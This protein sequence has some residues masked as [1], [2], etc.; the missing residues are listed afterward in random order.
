MSTSLTVVDK[1]SN[2]QRNG[3]ANSVA[4]VGCSSAG[5]DNAC[6][7]FETDSLVEDTV[8]EGGAPELVARAVRVS[9]KRQVFVKAHTA[10]PGVNSA[11]TQ[12]PAATGPLITL[13][14]APWDDL[15]SMVLKITQGGAQGVGQFA[16]SRDGVN[17]DGAIDIPLPKAAVV[18]GTVDLTTITLSS[19]NTL[20]LILAFDGG[21]NL[22]TTFSGITSLANVVTQINAAITTSGTASIVGGRYLQIIDATTGTSSTILLGSGTANAALG[23]TNAQTASGSA[24][25]YLIPKT[26]TT[27]TFPAGTYVLNVLYSWSATGPKMDLTSLANALNALQASKIPFDGLVVIAQ[28]P[29]DVFEL[30][31]IGTQASTS[32]ASFAANAPRLYS[33]AMIFTPLGGTGASAITANDTAIKNGITVEDD[34]KLWIVHG[35]CYMPGTAIKG[36]IRRPLGHSAAT[37]AAAYRLSS[38]LGNGQQ[39]SLEETSL[40]GPDLVTFARDESTASIKMRAQR[41]T[42]ALTKNGAPY[43]ARGV[44]RAPSTGKFKHAGVMRMTMLA[45]RIVDDAMQQYDNDDPFLNPDGTLRDPDAA[46]IKRT[47]DRALGVLVEDEHAS[48]AA[49]TVDTTEDIGATDNLTVSFEVQHKA[50]LQTVTGKLGIVSELVLG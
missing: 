15:A 4:F 2:V 41:F 46:A 44:T 29:V 24:A 13:S 27:V 36:Q 9:K 23:F 34:P 14:G 47:I 43:I 16:I 7:Q 45:A 48:S 5:V 37:R 38:D 22:T 19:L 28:T 40:V 31:A 11:V 21:G 1:G 30:N 6:Y 25:T 3:G 49:C 18:V 35:D 42:V 17:F 50:Q 12:S 39:P 32:M 26:N 10:T 8:G 20:T 33:L